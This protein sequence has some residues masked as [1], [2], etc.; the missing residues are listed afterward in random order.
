MP[1]WAKD[2]PYSYWEA[3]PVLLVAPLLAVS[4]GASA[5]V[6]CSFCPIGLST[7]SSLLLLVLYY[8]FLLLVRVSRMVEESRGGCPEWSKNRR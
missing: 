2:A 8:L 6:S 3:I 4:Q 1:E 7:D 5:P